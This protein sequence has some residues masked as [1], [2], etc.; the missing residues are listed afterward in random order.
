MTLSYDQRL[1][2]VEETINKLATGLKIEM[3]GSFRCCPN[4]L[5]F[6]ETGEQCKLAA[7]RPPARVIAFGC[8]RFDFDIPF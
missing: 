7:A 8:E 1:R 5:H 6:D 3:R 4:C 2:E